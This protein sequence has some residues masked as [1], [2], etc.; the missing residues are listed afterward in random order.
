MRPLS[1]KSTSINLGTLWRCWRQRKEATC[2]YYKAWFNITE[3]HLICSR[4]GLNVVF[5][6]EFIPQLPAEKIKRLHRSLVRSN[7]LLYSFV[8]MN[9]FSVNECFHAMYWSHWN[10]HRAISLMY[11]PAQ[12]ILSYRQYHQVKDIIIF[13]FPVTQGPCLWTV[14]QVET[15]ILVGNDLRTRIRPKVQIYQFP[16]VNA[17]WFYIDIPR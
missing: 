4:P 9:K 17:L 10:N 3:H 2:G 13:C 1:S 12:I 7:L 15:I 11:R 6:G 8:Y 5:K 14:F 16:Y